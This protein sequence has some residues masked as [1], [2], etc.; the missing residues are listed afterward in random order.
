MS[1]VGLIPARWESRRFPGKPAVAIA[2]IPMIQR[3]WEGARKS[4]RLREVFI[5]TDDERIFSLCESFGAQAIMTSS[6]HLSGTDRIA[7]AAQDL[8][9]EWVVN[10]QGDEPLIESRVIDAAIEALEQAPDA[11]MSTVVHAVDPDSLADPNRVKVRLDERGRAVAFSRSV[12]LAPEEGRGP[13]R[14]IWQHVGLYVYRRSFLETFVALP[15][16]QSEQSEGLEQLRALENGFVIQAGIVEGW[17]GV[18]VDV[19]KDVEAVEKALR[20]R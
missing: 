1:I 2:G 18:S 7:E 15:P 3:V 9:D 4:D 19:P 16:G 5:A 13:D 12:P 6:A 11:D 10:I 14:E 8:P 17:R 20:Q